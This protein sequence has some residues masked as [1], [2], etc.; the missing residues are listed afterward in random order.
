L[1]TL[2]RK[3]MA[4]HPEQLA[5]NSLNPGYERFTSAAAA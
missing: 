3:E 4:E 2:L 5:S 1:I